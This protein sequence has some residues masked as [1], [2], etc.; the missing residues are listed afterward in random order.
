MKAILKAEGK[1]GFCLKDYPM[2][3]I[4][5]N[6]VLI[7]VDVYKRQEP[8]PCR[9]LCAVPAGRQ[10]GNL[11]FVE[12]DLRHERHSE[13]SSPD[14]GN[15]LYDQLGGQSRYSRMDSDHP[16]NVAVRFADDHLPGGD[17]AGSGGT[18]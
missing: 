1:P 5:R 10:R 13:P 8:V 7:K 4:G 12:A 9:L 17:Q 11:Y 6:E 16:E 14:D 3:E 2:P 18:G 15:R